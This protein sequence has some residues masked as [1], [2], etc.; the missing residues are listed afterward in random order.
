[1]QNRIS[2]VIAFSFLV[3]IAFTQSINVIPQPVSVVYSKPAGSF[4]ITPKTQ[5]VVHGTGQENSIFFLK[6]Y[7]KEYY[8]FNLMLWKDTP[9]NNTINLNYERMD[10][11]IPGA[12]TIEVNKYGIWLNGDNENGVFYAVQTLLQLLP[13]D[14]SEPAKIPFMKIT[15]YP[16]F[17]YR[18]LH[19]DVGR[20][21]FSVDFVKRYIDY[22]AY[23]KMNYFHWHLT[24][25]QGWRI[26]IKK[27]PRL[28]EIGGYRN[29][30]II[31]RY[32]GKGNDNIRYGGFYTQEETKDVVAYAAK[33]YITVVPEIE[34][35]GH[36][37][38][39]IAAYPYLSCFPNEKT[40]IRAD[41]ISEASKAA[42]GK[43]VQ[44]TWGVFD[45]VFCAGNDSTFAFLQDVIDEVIP[46]FPGKYIHVGGDECPKSNWKRC[47]KCQKR[48]KEGGL[49]DEHELQSYFIQRMEKYINGK[50]KTL[51]GW[52]EILEG[53]LAPNAVVMSWR[54]EQG[55]ITAA[56]QK[57]QVI[58]TPGNYVYFDHSQTKN[59]DS[60]TI[61]S[62]TPVQE[63][64]GYEPQSKQ[65]TPEQ[66]KFIIGAQG[67]VW[68]EYMKNPKKVEYMIFPRVSALSEVLWS[69][70]EKRNVK[71]FE[72]RLQSQ[73]KRYD[74][75]NA[76]YSKAFFDVTIKLIP[77]T[78]N[79]VILKL[80]HRLNE[81]PNYTY[82]YVD[83]IAPYLTEHKEIRQI[84]DFN[85]DPDGSKGI[86]KDTLIYGKSN[87]VGYK[88]PFPLKQS[89]KYTVYT[90]AQGPFTRRNETV[91][92]S[93][94]FVLTKST[95]KR[96]KLTNSSSENF[97]GEGGAFGLVNGIVSEKGQNSSEW[98]GWQGKDLDA[99]I[100]LGK[101]EKISKV[102]V[103]I[104]TARGSQPCKPQFLEISMSTNGV[105]YKP[106]GRTTEI[107]ND[108]LNMGKLSLSFKPITARFIIVKVKNFGT[109]PDGMPG[110]GNKA[111][112][113]AD[114]I[115]VE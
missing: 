75:W 114:E 41:M 2:L 43:L 22:I 39:A 16:R 103:H 68:T 113:Y 15:D 26:E 65:L 111:W 100:D 32:P 57:H 82:V 61:G 6:D 52:D 106:V 13:T 97:P 14:E 64:Y 38:A 90:S 33:R 74:L 42:T 77:S 95:G 12:Y 31:G 35:P 5:F 53:G 115:Q 112:L 44:E 25:D 94:N 92:P 78:N 55:G 67:N 19:L 28:T 27:Y 48:I 101:S 98:L 86:F 108:S 46:L 87:A 45:D 60:V 80:E 24:E 107:I 63:T 72:K 9:I 91:G 84:P 34:M 66:A 69:P 79:N 62:Y 18:G 30:T 70:K 89:G 73:F 50:G 8:G 47:P 56:K 76:N 110:A 49:K 83:V 21:F 99:T 71:D 23:H 58:M 105:N 96:I 93:I 3:T 102:K 109:I 17:E 11:P 10:H 81:N 7:M 88:G 51:I 59:E 36:G 54:G 85:K 4:T 40:K 29:G 104:L 37:S 1:M 20:H